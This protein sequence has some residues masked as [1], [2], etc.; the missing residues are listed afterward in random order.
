MEN[1]YELKVR[2]GSYYANSLTVLLW[3]VLKHRL[4]HLFK[5]GKWID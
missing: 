5:H 4:W 1:N 3:E 2:A